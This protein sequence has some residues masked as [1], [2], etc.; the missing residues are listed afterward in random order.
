[1]MEAAGIEGNFNKNS[2]RATKASR[3]YTKNVDEQLISEQTGHRS[4]CD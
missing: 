1:M 4:K 2:L 3:M